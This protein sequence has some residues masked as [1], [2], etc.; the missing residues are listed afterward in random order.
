MMYS[1][2]YVNYRILYLLIYLTVIS[3]ITVCNKVDLQFYYR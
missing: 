1:F 3:I 2:I